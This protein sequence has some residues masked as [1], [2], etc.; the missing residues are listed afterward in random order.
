MIDIFTFLE[1]KKPMKALSEEGENIFE[2]TVF[3]YICKKEF[4]NEESE[5]RVKDHCHIS[6]L[7]RGAAHQ[8][9]NLKYQINRNIPIVMHNLSGYDSHL[10]RYHVN[11]L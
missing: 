2:N 3:C 10:H 11:K 1:D 5:I 9:C 4:M 8:S 7:Y 6:G